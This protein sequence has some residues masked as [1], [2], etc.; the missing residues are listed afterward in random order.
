MIDHCKR[1]GVQRVLFNSNA[2]LL[3]VERAKKLAAVGLDE[4]RISFDGSSPEENDRIRVGSNFA[5]HAAIVKKVAKELP[6]KI[7]NVKFDGDPLPAKFLK[8]YFGTSVK[9]HTD[10]A[11][12]WAHNDKIHRP[13]TDAIYCSEMVE[14][15]TILSNGDV[16]MCCE[17]LLG[18]YRFG[19]VLLEMPLNIWTRMQQ[20][21]DAFGRKLYPEGCLGCWIVTG[22]RMELP[23]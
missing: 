1:I 21:R 17:D 2:S 5:K 10:P 16:V 18:D 4:L 15:M 23:E 7:Y 11:R 6:I 14:K 19:N 9:Y 13:T 8:D 20:F 12:I 22:A 3:T